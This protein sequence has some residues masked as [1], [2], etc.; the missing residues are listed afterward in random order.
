MGKIRKGRSERTP[1]SSITQ[2]WVKEHRYLLTPRDIEMLKLL[3][4][5]P[6]MKIEHLVELTPATYLPNGKIIKPFYEC[7]QGMKMC[8]DR[9]RR[10]FEYHFV[11]KYSPRLGLGEGTS[12]QY[13]WLDRAGYKLFDMPGRPNK[14]LTSE[15]Y[16]HSSIL[17]VYVLFKRLERLKIIQID[18]LVACYD[19][20]TD[21]HIVP[22]LI[23]CF[24]KGRYGYK[25]LI[26]VDTGEKRESDECK[27]IEK[28][29]DFELSGQWIK[30]SW[31]ELYRRR[32]PMILYL[33]T[34][35]EKRLKRRMNV[36][37]KKAES[38]QCRYDGL[39]LS[40]LEEKILSIKE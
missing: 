39:L 29:R 27:K 25:Y 34:S 30:E 22:D 28:Y 4:Q 7:N 5:F 9:I 23:V 40:S 19:I 16:H 15:Y 2:Q 33:F 36:F 14:T 38:V 8:R 21:Y 32:F 13:I 17:D 26:E 6:V 1:I 24:R 10:L 18:Y 37:K 20:Q 11:N 35:D 3:K 31:G 12:P